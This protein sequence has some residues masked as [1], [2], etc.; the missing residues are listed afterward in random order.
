MSLGELFSALFIQFRF[1]CH[2]LATVCSLR[3]SLNLW[4]L[5]SC[6]RS[7]DGK[8]EGQKDTDRL[9]RVGMSKVEMD[10]TEIGWMGGR[11]LDPTGSGKG[12]GWAVVS[13]GMHVRVA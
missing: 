7:L 11:G 2:R 12:P 6:F 9:D 8:R 3:S 10:L 4:P 5:S 1:L 13:T